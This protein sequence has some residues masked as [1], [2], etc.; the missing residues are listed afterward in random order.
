M[1]AATVAAIAAT[2]AAAA[3]MAASSAAAAMHVPI[4]TLPVGMGQ[5]AMMM[6]GMMQ[7]PSAFVEVEATI[8]GGSPDGESGAAA[9]SKKNA[10]T[11]EE[12]AIL[13]R[14]VAQEGAG[15]WTKV[16]AHLPHRMG[17]Q[18]RE[19]WFNHLAPDVKKGYWTAE[20]DRLILDAVREHGTKWSTIQKK[21]PGRSDNSI[22]NRYYS[23]IR[24]AQRLEKRSSSG[25]PLSAGGEGGMAGAPG[26][27]G[28]GSEYENGTLIASPLGD[29]ATSS[30][31]PGAAGGPVLPTGAEAA[32]LGIGM[33]H[34]FCSGSAAG[35]PGGSPS[36][37]K[38]KAASASVASLIEAPSQAAMMC[39]VVTSYAGEATGSH[40]ILPTAFA[41]VEASDADADAASMT[42][43]PAHSYPAQ[44]HA[45]S[46]VYLSHTFAPTPAP[47]PS[48]H[49]VPPMHPMLHPVPPPALVQPTH[50]LLQPVTS[51]SSSSQS[52]ERA[53]AKAQ[54]MEAMGFRTS[55]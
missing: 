7:S 21:L 13:T 9:A 36:G 53:A 10:W 17:R 8:A 11:P 39:A 43:I 26:G 35:S 34:N 41:S 46:A 19:R 32:A 15:H 47:T 52:P 40:N 45:A 1:D 31:V 29:G 5:Q 14:V 3:A 54:A 18:C 55:P 30:L 37:S 38:R 12:D 28:H 6:M 49:L 22:K 48:S 51:S 27:S 16:A 42:A 20:E 25:D 2:E 4:S 33:R 24:K 44:A 50:P 23:A